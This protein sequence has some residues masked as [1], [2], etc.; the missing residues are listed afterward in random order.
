MSRSEGSPGPNPV[1]VSLGSALAR[2]VRPNQPIPDEVDLPYL[3]D[4]LRHAD[5]SRNLPDGMFELIVDLPLEVALALDELAAT[6]G[7]SHA[8]TVRLAIATDLL[9]HQEEKAG[10]T[11]ILHRRGRRYRFRRRALRASMRTAL[12]HDERPRQS[13][14]ISEVE[15]RGEEMREAERRASAAEASEEEA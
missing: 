4:A 9:L 6:Y 13:I 15:R 5:V 14:D 8:E 12:M 10:G 2:S 7:A 1:A 3:R 11:L